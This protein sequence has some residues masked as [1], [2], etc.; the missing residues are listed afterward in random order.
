MLYSP[1][2]DVTTSDLTPTIIQFY[3]SPA[4]YPF[5]KRPPWMSKILKSVTRWMFNVFKIGGTIFLEKPIS[6]LMIQFS[7]YSEITIKLLF[8]TIHNSI[9]SRFKYFFPKHFAYRKFRKNIL[10]SYS[11]L[12]MLICR[13]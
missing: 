6:I 2:L 11:V 12:D 7:V 3:A 10:Y 4:G 1:P 5:S 13:N 8:H 9:S